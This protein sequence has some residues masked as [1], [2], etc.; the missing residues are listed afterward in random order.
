MLRPK[1]LLGL[2]ATPERMDGL[3]ILQSFEGQIAA[4]IRLPDAINRK[5]LCPFQYF[6]VTDAV[7]YRNL[8]WQGGGYATEDLDNL[9]TGNDVRLR[10]VIDKVRDTLLDVTQTRGLGFCVSIRHAVFMA[11]AFCNAGIPSMALSAL[12]S[13]EIRASARD[14]LKNL[15]IN[16]IFTV[17]LYNEGV[18]IPEVDAVLMLRPTESLT[19]FLQQLGRGLRLHET[20]ECL[21]VLDFIG[22]AHKNFSYGSRFRALLG[23]SSRR[24]EDEIHQGFPHLPSGCFVNLERIAMQHVLNNIRE[25]ITQGRSQIVRRIA[26]FEQETTNRLSLS[27]FVTFHRLDLDEIY[28]RSSWSRLLVSARLKA[29]FHE[30]DEAQL[31]KGLR[32]SARI[33]AL[34]YLD[35]AL[36]FLEASAE[37]LSNLT[38][39]EETRR[40]LVMLQFALWSRNSIPTTLAEGLHRLAENRTLSNELGE[41]LRHKRNLVSEISLPLP[42]PFLCPL[43]LHCDYSRDE[44]L[45][46][47]GVWTLEEQREVRE[48]VVFVQNLP[49]DLFFITLNKTDRDYSPTTMYDDYAVSEHMF[50][51]QSQ[52]TISED[53]PTGQRYISHRQLGSEVLLFV[54]EDK[55]NNGASCPYTFLGPGDYCGHQGSRPMSILWRL[56]HRMPAKL[57]RKVRRLASD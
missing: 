25:S 32:R 43:E 15:D 44:I 20:K 53:S 41:L 24:I 42:L 21:T 6:G 52:S 19:V 55:R 9:V 30:P 4:E 51:W 47:L 50:H 40:L 14:R 5:L 22:Q 36:R 46:G 18:D 33:N 54:R 1:V 28:R 13:D 56:R 35:S 3:D 29:D 31:S 27:E 45:A 17:D 7:D 48:G 11:E 39:D 34:K 23:P 2:T 8:R 26:S 16:F 10:L 12:S 49:A 37:N 57:L 38:S